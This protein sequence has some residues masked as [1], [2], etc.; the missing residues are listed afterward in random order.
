MPVNVH[1]AKTQI[2]AASRAVAEVMPARKKLGLP[3]DIARNSPLVPPGDQWWVPL[4][5]N[6]VAAWIEGE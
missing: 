5:D 2:R 4:T 1:E 6:E 3:F